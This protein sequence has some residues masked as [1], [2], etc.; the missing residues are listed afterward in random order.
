MDLI[1]N[2]SKIMKNT[3]DL[4][5]LWLRLWFQSLLHPSST[6]Q[7]LSWS[8]HYHLL[9]CCP[10]LLWIQEK[11]NCKALTS[12]KLARGR[13]HV[14]FSCFCYTP[15]PTLASVSVNLS[16]FFSVLKRALIQNTLSDFL[17]C[18][19]MC[20]TFPSNPSTPSYH[21]HSLSSFSTIWCPWFL[22][23]SLFPALHNCC[24]LPPYQTHVMESLML[25][26]VVLFCPH[27]RLVSPPCRPRVSLMLLA[28][29]LL[30]AML[31]VSATRRWGDVGPQGKQA[32]CLCAWAGRCSCIFSGNYC[33]GSV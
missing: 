17:F 10:F 16:P 8:S 13:G 33:Y 3:V 26:V 14:Y 5:W 9:F 27:V 6:S 20:V 1:L 30:A 11:K 21:H 12:E 7:T 25:S 31:V 2:L 28:A 32:L 18:W 22:R 29:V 4:G 19:V 23:L 24:F 15:N